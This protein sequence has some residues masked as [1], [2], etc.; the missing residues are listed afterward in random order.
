VPSLI[1]PCGSAR[2]R[3]TGLFAHSIDGAGAQGQ[4]LA[5][6]CGRPIQVKAAR[7]TLIPFQRLQ[8]SVVAEIPDEVAGS[9]LAVEQRAQRLD[10]VSIDQQ[11]RRK[12]NRFG[13]L[14]KTAKLTEASIFG[15]SKP[16]PQERHFLP[17]ARAAVS[18]PENR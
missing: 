11:H 1:L 2:E 15:G 8:L 4:F 17:G 7:P 18:V 16:P 10:A 13:D 14:G 6:A 3:N 12:L 9:R 5:A